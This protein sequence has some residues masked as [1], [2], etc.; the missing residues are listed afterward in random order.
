MVTQTEPQV[1]ITKDI[2][3]QKEAELKYTNLLLMMT[4]LVNNDKPLDRGKKKVFMKHFFRHTQACRELLQA[5]GESIE[6]GMR[7][8]Y[9]ERKP[10][11]AAHWKAVK[12]V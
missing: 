8:R 5:N 2:A 3:K 4:W 10:N 12:Q 1:A 11:V 7:I 6:L 9:A